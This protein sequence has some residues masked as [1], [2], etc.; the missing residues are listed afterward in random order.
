MTKKQEKDVFS[1][2]I[3][4]GQMETMLLGHNM[5]VM[6]QSLKGVNGPPLPHGLSVMNMYTEVTFGS[7]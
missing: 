4:H 2:K 3:I 5:H 7:K 6:T 1:S